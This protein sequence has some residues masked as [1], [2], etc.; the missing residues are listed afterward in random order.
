MQI[1]KAKTEYSQYRIPGVVLTNRG[2]L[3]M[4]YE[5]RRSDH[6]WADID[7]KIIRSTDKGNTWQTVKRIESHGN[8]M[9]N[10]VIIA[11]GDTLHLLYLE[12]YRRLFCCASFDD[13]RTFSEPRE[14]TAELE[15]YGFFFNAVAVGPGHGIVHNG[16]LLVPIWFARNREDKFAHGPSFIHVLYSK[17][18]GASWHLGDRIAEDVLQD[19]SECAL[20]VTAENKVLISIR[21]EN[22]CRRRAFAVSE[23]GYSDWQGFRFAANMPDPICQGSMCHQNGKVFHLNCASTEKRGN[24]TL[25][26]TKDN[27]ETYESLL[28]ADP[29]G[30]ADFAVEGDT[31]YILYEQ[32]LKFGGLYFKTVKF[33]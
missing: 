28:I 6:D 18:N 8:T 5:C 16:T 29:A 4:Y 13:G 21:N 33:G 30:Y 10:P 11:N 1:E 7:I 12:N 32:D 23:N 9:N 2:T 27:F 14:I 22:D 31:A 25:K 17:D 24:L 3:L 15:K 20:A 19:P 26:I